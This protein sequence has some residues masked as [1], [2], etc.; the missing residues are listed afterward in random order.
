MLLIPILFYGPAIAFL[1]PNFYFFGRAFAY[2][3]ETQNSLSSSYVKNVGFKKTQLKSHYK[4]LRGRN[5]KFEGKQKNFQ[6][7][8]EN[9]SKSSIADL[10]KII[11]EKLVDSGF[12]CL[13]K[14]S[15]H[16]GYR[17]TPDIRC[18]NY[19]INTTH[20]HLKSIATRTSS[21]NCTTNFI[22]TTSDCRTAYSGLTKLSVLRLSESQCAT[23]RC[24]HSFGPQCRNNGPQCRNN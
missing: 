9:K 4:W 3:P 2:N 18:A 21:S 17:L 23:A 12:P 15:A 24:Y 19:N 5:P 10:N 13:P 1:Y 14:H 22:T 20:S 16:L 6:S 7:M 11:N 8:G